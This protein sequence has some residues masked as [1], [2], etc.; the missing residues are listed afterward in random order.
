MAY[1]EDLASRIRALLADQPDIVEKKMFGGLAFMSR[2]NMC[3][4]IQKNDLVLRLGK[5]G[6]AEAVR[7]QGV[8]YFDFTG[9]PMTTMAVVREKDLADEK[10]LRYWV[11]SALA[12]AYTL[13]AK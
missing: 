1:D 12:F 5:D 11:E 4:G 10:S 2:G 9:K 8:D 6:A 7:R 3:C 13:P